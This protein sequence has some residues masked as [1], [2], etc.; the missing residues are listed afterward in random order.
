MV[1]KR[2]GITPLP[3]PNREVK[4]VC[5]DGTAVYCGRVGSCREIDKLNSKF[6]NLSVWIICFRVASYIGRRGRVISLR[7]YS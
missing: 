6:K 7:I 3:I 2:Q 4:T 1:I 5:A